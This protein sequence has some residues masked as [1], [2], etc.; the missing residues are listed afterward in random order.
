MA[1]IERVTGMSQKN[2][3]TLLE[4]GPLLVEGEA[5]VYNTVS[6]LVAAE[7]PIHLCRCGASANKPFCDGSHTRIGFTD[8]CTVDNSKDEELEA[9]TPLTITCRPNAMLVIRGPVIIVGPDGTKARRN[10]AA[11][12]RCGASRNKPFCDISHKKIN[13]QD[14][15]LVVAAKPEQD[16]EE[17]ES[18]AEGETAAPA[19]LQESADDGTA[20]TPDAAP[21]IKQEPDAE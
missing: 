19:T 5:R 1:F 14:D 6:E 2:T 12:C 3:I 4:N 20:V 11:L 15:A 16:L 8:C 7:T 9:W 10:K 13:F 18:V 21:D 17:Q